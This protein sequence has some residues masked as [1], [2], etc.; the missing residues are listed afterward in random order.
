LCP[1]FDLMEGNKYAIQVT[2]HSCTA[3]NDKGW[4][5]SCDGDGTGYK[6]TAV[7]LDGSAYGPGDNFRINTNKEFHYKIDI[8]KGDN[9]NCTGVTV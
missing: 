9:D 4:Y 2:P 6:N 7:D 1:E 8:L 5:S 3:G